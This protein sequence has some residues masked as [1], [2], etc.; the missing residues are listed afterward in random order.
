MGR[1]LP[2]SQPAAA[3]AE[4]EL[5]RRSRQLA[6]R[7]GCTVM[8]TDPP[9]H[10]EVREAVARDLARAQALSPGRA[11]REAI[12]AVGREHYGDATVERWLSSACARPFHPLPIHKPKA[13]SRHETAEQVQGA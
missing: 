9:A 13:R 2:Q 7:I 11:R 1:P 3:V 10:P 6:L 12:E 8:A 4:A 5:E